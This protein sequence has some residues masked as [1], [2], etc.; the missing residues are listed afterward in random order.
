MSRTRYQILRHSLRFA[1]RQGMVATIDS[2]VRSCPGISA[3]LQGTCVY[4][5]I[6]RRMDREYQRLAE[7]IDI[8]EYPVPA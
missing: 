6:A 2:V 8:L 7:G 4:T 3:T 5:A 1:I